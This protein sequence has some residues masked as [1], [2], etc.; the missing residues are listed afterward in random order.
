MLTLTGGTGKFATIRGIVK[1]TTSA[2]P[3]AGFNEGQVEGHY[4]LEK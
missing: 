1:T 4:W 3:R 2:D